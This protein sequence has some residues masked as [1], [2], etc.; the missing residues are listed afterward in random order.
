[1]LT[2]EEIDMQKLWQAAIEDAIEQLGNCP[3]NMHAVCERTEAAQFLSSPAAENAFEIAYPDRGTERL[4]RV[5]A[6]LSPCKHMKE[7][8][9][10]LNLMNLK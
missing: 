6:Q 2:P 3:E 10:L 8:E 4:K 5:R 1:M 9:R 7:R